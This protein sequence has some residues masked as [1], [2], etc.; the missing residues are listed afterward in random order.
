M[1]PLGSDRELLVLVGR[2]SQRRSVVATQSWSRRVTWDLLIV[3]WRDSRVVGFFP[4][5]VRCQPTEPC[6]S[7]TCGFLRGRLTSRHIVVVVVVTSY[8]KSASVA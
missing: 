6:D 3:L 8:Y 7:V 2:T 4:G 1:Y 5:K